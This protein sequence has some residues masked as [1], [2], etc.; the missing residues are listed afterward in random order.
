M[1]IIYRCQ[2]DP[3]KLAAGP[4]EGRVVALGS[5][6]PA[7]EPQRFAMDRTFFGN[8]RFAF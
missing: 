6:R 1:R 3:N 4:K 8:P 2:A 5:E 7:Q